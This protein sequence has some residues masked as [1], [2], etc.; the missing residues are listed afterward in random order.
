MSKT[1]YFKFIFLFS[2]FWPS[3][4][5]I[6]FRMQFS[7]MKLKNSM[8]RLVQFIFWGFLRDSLSR[9][10]FRDIHFPE[11]FLQQCFSQGFTFQNFFLRNSFSRNCFFQSFILQK[12]FPHRFIFFNFFYFL[13]Q[14]F[15]FQNIF[16]QRF[17]FQKCFPQRFIFQ[18]FFFSEVYFPEF[19]PRDSLSITLLN[20]KIKSSKYEK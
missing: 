16:F 4:I 1:K 8:I 13:S 12:C 18:N 11:L 3:E 17:I 2:F 19:F 15:T 10:F 6:G 5:N 7:V 20:V 14:R 9:I